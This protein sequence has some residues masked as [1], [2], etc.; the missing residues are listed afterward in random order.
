MKHCLNTLYISSQETYLSKEGECVCIHLKEG[1]KRKIPIHNLGGL[2]LFGQ[3]SCSPFLLGHCA[4]HGVAVSWL[5][6]N[7][8]FLASMHGAVSGNV[9][10][11]RAQYRK[12]DDPAFAA[13]LARAFLIG[14]IY[15]CRT[16]LRRTNRNQ[17]D[18]RLDDVCRRFSFSLA[19]LHKDISLEE[20]RGVEGNAAALY[21]SVFDA[22]IASSDSTFVFTGRS[23]RP[24]LDAMNC[25]LSFLYTLLAHDVRS[26]LEGVGLDPAA[27]YLHK[28]RPG[29]PSLALDMMEEFRPYLADRLACTLVNKGQ[30]KNKG[31]RR[32][33]AGAVLMDDDTRK[34]VIVAWQKRKQDE[35][36]HPF[37]QEKMRIGLLWHIQARLLARYIRGDMDAYP[38]FVVR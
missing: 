32:Q 6:E 18:S 33:E 14:K 10:L 26:A 20:A 30:V 11:R 15:N 5:T 12:A 38:P 27:G 36:E 28:D 34:E 16:L 35:I 13:K 19:Q 29:R 24:P 1:E 4:E 25:L 31:F 23:R 21:F 37:L 7:G 2:V 9:L 17:P 8:R 22:Q 3:V